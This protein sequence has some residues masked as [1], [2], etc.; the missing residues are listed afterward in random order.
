MTPSFVVL[1]SVYRIVLTILMPDG[2]VHCA[3]QA[4]Q[5]YPDKHLPLELCVLCFVLLPV[6]S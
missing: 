3:P 2:L 4:G 1:S 5:K 6:R